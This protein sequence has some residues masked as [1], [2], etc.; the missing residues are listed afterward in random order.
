MSGVDKIIEK[1]CYDYHI[2]V[3]E[4]MCKTSIHYAA[5]VKSLVAYVL[6]F[7]TKLTKYKIAELMHVHH[8]TIWRYKEIVSEEIRRNPELEN[9][10]KA[11]GKQ[12]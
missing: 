9:K 6:L 7:H 8:Y 1:I 4:V 10:L 3:E 5:R 12:Q 2:P 11:Y